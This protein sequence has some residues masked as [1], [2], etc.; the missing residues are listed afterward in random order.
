MRQDI[1]DEFCRIY[2]LTARQTLGWLR[3]H[4]GSD[5]A[6]DL[7]Q[8]VYEE[9]LKTLR[10]KGIGYIDDAY[11]FVRNLAKSRLGKRRRRQKPTELPL[12]FSDEDGE[13]L[14]RWLSS[15]F[16][17]EDEVARRDLAERVRAFVDGESED[18]RQVFYL[19]FGAELTLAE[20]AD[21]L[22]IPESTVKSRL[23]RLLKKIRENFEFEVIE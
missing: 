1:A 13:E 21:E 17:L 3:A 16:V 6:H 9:L 15:G 8:E 12:E 4:A 5:E 19:H 18:S 23:Y 14:E 10:R 20:C 11:A 22:G 7:F 2:D